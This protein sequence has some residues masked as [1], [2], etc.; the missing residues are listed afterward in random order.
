MWRD[1]LLVGF[2]GALG[3]ML[4]FLIS[5]GIQTPS[6]RFPAATLTANLLGCVLI[7][8][9]LQAHRHGW[10]SDRSKLV[11]GVGFLGGL[12]TLSAMS[13]ETIDAWEKGN[14]SQGLAYLVITVVGG[15]LAVAL[16]IRVLR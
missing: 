4:R 2:A 6:A 8:V 3:C 16:G 5:R 12:T 9:L 15:L 10:V 14:L 1:C 7:G 11:L 13:L